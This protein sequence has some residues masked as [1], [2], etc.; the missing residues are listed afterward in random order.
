MDWK[1][2]LSARRIGLATSDPVVEPEERFES[3]SPYLKD[4]DRIVYSSA[5]RRLQ[6]KTQV[7]SF[8]TSDYVRKLA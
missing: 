6:D 8:P 7:Y 2:L 5:F 1:Q 3:R 4:Y